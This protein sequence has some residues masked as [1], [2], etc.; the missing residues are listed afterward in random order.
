[1][2]LPI[3]IWLPL[4]LCPMRRF[5]S[6]GGKALYEGSPVL[7]RVYSLQ[8]SSLKG[9]SPCPPAH[10]D[11]LSPTQEQ[12][13]SN[14]R[15]HSRRSQQWPLP[16]MLTKGSFLGVQPVQLHRPHARKSHP[17]FTALLDV[18]APAE[19]GSSP[20]DVRLSGSHRTSPLSK[21]QGPVRPRLCHCGG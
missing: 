2:H 13:D 15:I 10:S 5:Q 4:P 17:C 9:L 18:S 20:L 12:L 7:V 21:T 8:F 14:S 16:P 11:G 6:R 19:P 3:P 1:M